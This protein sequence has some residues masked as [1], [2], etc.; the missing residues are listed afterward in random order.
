[1][2]AHVLRCKLARPCGLDDSAL[3]PTGPAE[4]VRDLDR[5][6]LAEH[7]PDL[8]SKRHGVHGPRLERPAG[9]REKGCVCHPEDAVAWLHRF[10]DRECD[11]RAG[12][13]REDVPALELH[14]A[15][16]RGEPTS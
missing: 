6:R 8:H 7:G 10:R 1:M 9:G 5:Q 11:A 13:R 2:L 14:L 4:V 3:G 15:R 16:S 12:G